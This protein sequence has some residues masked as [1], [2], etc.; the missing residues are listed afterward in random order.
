M[1]TEWCVINGGTGRC[2]AKSYPL[3]PYRLI[4]GVAWIGVFFK[5]TTRL[6]VQES[7]LQSYNHEFNTL[8]NNPRTSTDGET[9][10]WTNK[11]WHLIFS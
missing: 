11:E 8:T 4:N 6:S 7:T 10:K 5:K 3:V 2:K 1:V 9:I